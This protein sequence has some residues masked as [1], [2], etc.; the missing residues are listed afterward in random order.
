MKK[1]M[2]EIN[3]H[4]RGRRFSHCTVTEITV[5]WQGFLPGREGSSI[6]AI[7]SKGERFQGSPDDY[8]DTEE[9]AWEAVMNDLQAT[10]EASEEKV[11]ELQAGALVLKEYLEKIKE[12]R[13]GDSHG[14][15]S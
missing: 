2:Y 15:I 14:K 12:S 10:L 3:W 7:D 11:E 8:F 5:I 1:T 6:T 13:K 4:Y 9:G